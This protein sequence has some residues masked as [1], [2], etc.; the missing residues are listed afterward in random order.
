MAQTQIGLN[1]ARLERL[2]HRAVRVMDID[3]AGMRVLTEAATGPF[4]ATAVIA[5]LAGADV[6]AVARDSHWGKAK[7]AIDAT[8]SLAERVGVLDRI[9]FRVGEGHE[10]ANGCDI[11]TNLGFIR[12]IDA[13]TIGVLSP[14][15]VVSLMWEPWEFR[16]GDIDRNALNAYGVPLIGTNENHPEVRTLAYLGPTVGRLLL[17]V[18]I[19]IVRAH[20]LVMG[21]DPFGSVVA[22]WLSRAGAMVKSATWNTWREVLI[23]NRPWDALVLVE[24]LEM[25]TVIGADDAT[26]LK[27]LAEDGVPIVRL[28]GL[29]ERESILSAGVTL[30]PDMDVIAGVMAVTTAYAGPRPVIDLHAA[31]LKVGGLIVAAR[32]NGANLKNAIAAAVSSGYAL[33]MKDEE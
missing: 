7:T 3:L 13:R 1:K 15:A 27:I 18:H 30:F 10:F 12:P 20:I 9:A 2:C 31:G 25:S 6:V 5:A 22:G 8:A 32:R 29:V 24:H 26:F 33:A 28:C 11:V 4:A 19:E 14:Y 23:A 21:S 16:S 17:E